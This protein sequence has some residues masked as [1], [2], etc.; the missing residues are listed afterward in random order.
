MSNGC[1]WYHSLS[2]SPV[3]VL[4]VFKCLLVDGIDLLHL[5]SMYANALDQSCEHAYLIHERGDMWLE[6]NIFFVLCIECLLSLLWTQH[7][8]FYCPEV[9]HGLWSCVCMHWCDCNG[10]CSLPGSLSMRHQFPVS[11]ILVLYA[12]VCCEVR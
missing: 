5:H 8:R 11:D 9:I 12:V 3:N 6:H 7:G 1:R 4:E 10:C 2:A